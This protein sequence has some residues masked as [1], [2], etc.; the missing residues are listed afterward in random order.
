MHFLI[1]S[2]SAGPACGDGQ[3]V[4]DQTAIYTEDEITSELKMSPP[5][6]STPPLVASVSS[7]TEPD[8][9][10]VSCSKNLADAEVESI[11]ENK[12]IDERT[13]GD[14]AE[15]K[16]VQAE[17]GP[18]PKILRDLRRPGTFVKS[19]DCLIA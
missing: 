10:L 3:T 11:D 16:E 13:E 5:D 15:V 14:G 4:S 12:E 18:I 2:G 19:E 6:K 7:D 9:S 8:A 17:S 1:R